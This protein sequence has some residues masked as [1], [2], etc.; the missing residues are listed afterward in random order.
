VL[1]IYKS[2]HPA[3][4]AYDIRVTALSGWFLHLRVMCFLWGTN[5][6]YMYYSKVSLKDLIETFG[7]KSRQKESLLLCITRGKFQYWVAQIMRAS[8]CFQQNERTGTSPSIATILGKLLYK[9]K[10]RHTR[11]NT[12]LIVL[13]LKEISYSH[14]YKRELNCI[15]LCKIL[16][17]HGGD[18]EERRLLGFYAVWR[19]FA[20]CVG[21]QLRLTLFLVHQCL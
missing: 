21:C 1:W 14:K 7:R 17:F 6:I 9:Q 11:L 12:V 15:E 19:S 8:F 18:Y 3:H 10:G 13:C 4:R 16:D 20:A 5:W 2:L